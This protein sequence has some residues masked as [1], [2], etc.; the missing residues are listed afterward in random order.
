M[1]FYPTTMITTII[2]AATKDKSGE[3]WHFKYQPINGG[4]IVSKPILNH[5]RDW[6]EI[7]LENGEG[8][9]F[10]HERQM[11]WAMVDWDC[12]DL[13]PN[14]GTYRREGKTLS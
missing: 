5:G 13:P 12:C 6:V 8:S 9:L 10:V 7:D 11:A 1:G 4:P 14:T 2:N 3:G